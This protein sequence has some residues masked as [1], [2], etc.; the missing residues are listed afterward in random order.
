MWSKLRSALPWRHKVVNNS[1][2]L[3][4]VGRQDSG[5]YICN[6]TNNMG[7]SEVTIMLEVESECLL[8]I[9]F[10]YLEIF[11]SSFQS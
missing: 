4:S 2:V 8:F 3:Q 1:L 7:T 5:E 6:A 9:F 10:F 11:H